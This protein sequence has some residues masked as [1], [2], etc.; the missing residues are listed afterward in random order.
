MG[1]ST[2]L[3]ADADRSGREALHAD[4]GSHGATTLRRAGYPQHSMGRA[5]ERDRG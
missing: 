2:H 5:P 4:R 3:S 1:K